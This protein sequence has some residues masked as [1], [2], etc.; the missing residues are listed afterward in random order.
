MVGPPESLEVRMRDVSHWTRRILVGIAAVAAG[1]CEWGDEGALGAQEASSGD[2]E[3][4]ARRL[5]DLNEAEHTDVTPSP[6]GTFLAA[7]SWTN[8][9]GSLV[10]RDLTAEEVESRVIRSGVPLHHPFPT[11]ISPDGQWIAFMV[12]LPEPVGGYELR[13][14][15]SDGSRERHLVTM[16]HPDSPVDWAEAYDWSPDGKYLLTAFWMSDKT[17][18]LALLSP[19]DGSKTILRAFGW[20]AAPDA[21]A[22]S[23]DGRSV[24]YDLPPDELKSARDLYLLTINGGREVRLTNTPEAK[25]AIGWS[26]DGSSFYYAVRAPVGAGAVSS[27]WRLPMQQERP[28]GSPILVRADIANASSFTFGGESLFY[29]VNAIEDRNVWSLAVDL[30]TGRVVEPPAPFTRVPAAPFA[31][32][33]SWTTDG[34]Y[35]THV[36]RSRGQRPGLELVLQSASNGEERSIPLGMEVVRWHRPERDG[37]VLVN[38]TSRGR[39][40]LLRV[41][42]VTG[43]SSP[44][45]DA[46]LRESEGR[47]DIQFSP[48]GATRYFL[49]ESSAAFELVARDVATG[50]ERVLVPRVLRQQNLDLPES[51]RL[52]PDGRLIAFLAPAESAPSPRE[53][54]VISVA[55]GESR[56]IHPSAQTPAGQGAAAPL[57]WTS[58]SRM[59][60]FR[61]L[62]GG[63]GPQLWSARADGTRS[64]LLLWVCSE[65]VRE[66]GQACVAGPSP[67]GYP[68]HLH[69]NDRRIVYVD[70]R[71]L[72]PI[73]ELWVLENLPETRAANRT[74]PPR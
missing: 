29:T 55:G 20:S 66:S 12:A 40:A 10:V 9:V 14:I 74:S 48:D 65:Q 52:S 6:D 7:V 26:R 46:E 60:V 71:P 54:R 72:D 57:N 32:Q 36:R 59:L 34:Q 25:R 21:A 17:A 11:R 45:D 23:T 64:D 24:V 13:S 1:G 4:T 73:S 70:N 44:V 19:E 61:H 67:M 5:F 41:D 43:Q 39:P 8:D 53:L 49:R 58:D 69:P 47:W 33:I 3:V 28:V 51:F 37:S 68:P 42:L 38:G 62:T 50:M 30:E 56:R 15:R 27:V 18:H 31:M 63:L 22:F 16:E 35:L 2:P